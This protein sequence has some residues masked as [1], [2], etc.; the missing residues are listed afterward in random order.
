MHFCI[1]LCKFLFL[2]IRYVIL[3]YNTIENTFNFP[4]S[5][6]MGDTTVWQFVFLREE[7]S[8]SWRHFSNLPTVIAKREIRDCVTQNKFK[9]QISDF[10]SS[11]RGQNWENP[12][13]HQSKTIVEY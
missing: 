4:F 1:S 10:K 13:W 6:K 3:P 11:A 2:H 9:F 5:L 7:I 8:F 12:N